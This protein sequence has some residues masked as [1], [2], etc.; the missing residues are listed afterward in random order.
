MQSLTEGSDDTDHPSEQHP[1]QE[2]WM[3]LADL[4][5]G[6]FVNG[7]E[8]TLQP[9]C[10]YDWQQDNHNYPEHLLGEI[11]SWIKSKKLEANVL[12]SIT[13]TKC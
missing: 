13:S 12:S 8:A 3:L 1:Q 9:D 2:E 11:P 4:V 5:P 6:L 10:N 7:Y